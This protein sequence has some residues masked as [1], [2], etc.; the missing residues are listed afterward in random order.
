MKGNNFRSNI[1][2]IVFGCA[3]TTIGL[4]ST[5]LVIDSD[6][7]KRIG[8]TVSF[9]SITNK[10]YSKFKRDEQLDDLLGTLDESYEKNTV[11]NN[12]KKCETISDIFKR[13]GQLEILDLGDE[14]KIYKDC[15][16][17]AALQHFIYEQSVEN[18]IPFDFLMAIG[19]A[20][21][22]GNFNAS[23][24]ATYNADSNTYDLGYLQLNTKSSVPL[25]AKKYN[26]RFEDAWEL[27]QNNDYANVCAAFL[28]IE[29][30]N[31]NHAEFNAYEYAGCYNG[32][33]GWRNYDT[34]KD[35]VYKHFSTAYNEIFT[36]HHFV[37]E[38]SQDTLKQYVK[39]NSN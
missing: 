5:V 29:E 13:Q 34:S 9:E 16:A 31:K 3:I 23:G 7:D 33:L 37:E 36:N 28:Q 4:F 2:N 32:W 15:P 25:F 19:Y 26:L 1:S 39:V 11:L 22:R 10:D 27:V 35:Y 38:K 6:N 20:E 24:K 18:K 8:K 14:D 21:T 30:I 12:F 17:S